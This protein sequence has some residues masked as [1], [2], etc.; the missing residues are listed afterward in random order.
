MKQ[1]TKNR[2]IFMLLLLLLV[3]AVVT[4]LTINTRGNW[5]FAFHLRSGRII[6]FI[7]V[8]ISTTIATIVFQTIT[9]NN[10]LTP[11]IIGLDSLYVLLQTA[12]IFFLGINHHFVTHSRLNFFMSTLLMVCASLGLYWIFFKRYPG[13]LYL[14]LMTGLI[15]GRLMGSLNTFLQVLIDPNDF[16]SVFARTVASFNN[17]DIT[18]SVVAA[19]LC[20]PALMYLFKQANVLDVLHLGRDHARGLGVDVDVLNLKLFIVISILTAVSTAL[21][22]PV[23]FLGFLGANL[24]Y[25]LFKTY[26]HT[27][28]FVG[29]SLITIIFIFF[30]QTIVEHIFRLQTTLGV[31]IEFI[32]G[33]YFLFIL[34]KERNQ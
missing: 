31:V 14:L 10:I 6:A 4:Y 30:G 19:L 16:E 11:N 3:V 29:G 2:S 12:T 28:L 25:Q 33:V 34:L 9:Q 7:L 23:T 17:V 1:Q 8:G 20:V 24:S 18:L 13:R 15:L 26:Q 32:G 5:A 22:G 21:V 27:Q